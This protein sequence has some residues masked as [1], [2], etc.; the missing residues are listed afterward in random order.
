MKANEYIDARKELQVAQK[1]RRMQAF[2]MRQ[3]GLTFQEIG[4][5]LGV[6]RQGAAQLVESHRKAKEK[7]K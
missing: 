2:T 7:S 6:T 5:A 3:K 4:D 1:K